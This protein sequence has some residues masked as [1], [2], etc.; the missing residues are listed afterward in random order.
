MYLSVLKCL[1]LLIC[2]CLV[3][4]FSFS[5]SA[6]T[7]CDNLTISWSGGN[8]PFELLITPFFHVPQNISIPDSAH[9]DS[10]NS[11]S[12]SLQLQIPP[13]QRFLLTMS[14]SQGFESGGTSDI[15]TVGSSISGDNCNLT[16]PAPD[17]TF[18]A[19]SALQQCR[20]FTFSDY[21]N[22]AQPVRILGL[23]PLGRHFELDPP[24]SSSDSFDWTANVLDGTSI[25]FI[26]TDSEGRKGG[27]SDLRTVGISDDSSC[28]DSSS[29]SSTASS[30]QTGAATGATETV[31]VNNGSK[32]TGAIVG[33][34]VGGM[35]SLS[36]AFLLCFC[37]LRRRQTRSGD[38]TSVQHSTSMIGISDKTNG[39]SRYSRI[40]SAL[41]PSTMRIRANPSFDL[42]PSSRPA[43][44]RQGSYPHP[45]DLIPNPYILPSEV[46]AV[47][48]HSL[49]RPSSIYLSDYQ[50]SR[51]STS[52][53]LPTIKYPHPTSPLPFT[54]YPQSPTTVTTRNGHSFSQSFSDTPIFSNPHSPTSPRSQTR[55]HS[56]SRPV[57][58]VLHTDLEDRN[59][60]ED[61]RSSVVELP[62]EYSD[63]RPPAAR[64]EEG[65]HVQPNGT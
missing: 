50:Q 57:R 62:P 37:C 65:K 33:G 25:T 53:P 19:N 30:T 38:G 4:A 35:A 58:L 59:S 23:I 63:R 2:P 43:A 44:S 7:S 12:F 22:A 64:I 27:S 20:T 9:D 8:G 42:L 39:S 54:N 48:G 31:Q 24:I 60:L 26:M 46:A 10:T 21:Y 18:Q 49:T 3:L 15:L 40:R 45:G 32:S 36:L 1:V 51:Q 16:E 61:D 5:F 28:I 52:A 13:G 14:D 11:G 17:F 56:Q 34:V 41:F 55:S 29:P 47:D 6:P